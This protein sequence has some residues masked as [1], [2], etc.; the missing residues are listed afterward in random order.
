M[1]GLCLWPLEELDPPPAR[2]S[3][4]ASARM[5]PLLVMGCKSCS[6]LATV[7]ELVNALTP[8]REWGPSRVMRPRLVKELFTRRV[9]FSCTASWAPA[10]LDN[11][12]ARTSGEEVEAAEMR[13]PELL[14][15]APERLPPP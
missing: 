7:P 8:K 6:W 12:L 14:L 4:P 5:M 3:C 9:A 10:A 1:M 15:T 13:P 2:V 11:R